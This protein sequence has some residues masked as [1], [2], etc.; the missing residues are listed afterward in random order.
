MDA[1][2]RLFSSPIARL[3]SWIVGGVFN[4]AGGTLAAAFCSARRSLKE[5]VLLRRRC[6][7]NPVE[8]ADE[9]GAGAGGVAA[10]GSRSRISPIREKGDGTG[11]LGTVIVSSSRSTTNRSPRNAMVV[12]D[13]WR[14]KDASYVSAGPAAQK[15]KTGLQ[16]LTQCG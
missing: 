3:S 2:W 13:G 6:A 1:R 14:E 7:G 8:E 16:R 4:E 5:G 10:V 9:G 11:S 15:A 12:V